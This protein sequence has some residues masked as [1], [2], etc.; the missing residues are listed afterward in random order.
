MITTVYAIVVLGLEEYF[1]DHIYKISG[2]IG[3]VFGLAV[4]FFLGFRIP[5]V[6]RQKFMHIIVMEKIL[7]KPNNQ[8]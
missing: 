8:I 2:Q 1:G 7:K 5:E 4:A 6:L 3:S